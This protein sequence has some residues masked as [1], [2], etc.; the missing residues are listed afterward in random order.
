MSLR[1]ASTLTNPSESEWTFP[2]YIAQNRWM[3]GF[4]VLSCS[5]HSLLRLIA[6]KRTLYSSTLLMSAFLD[7]NYY[8]DKYINLRQEKYNTQTRIGNSYNITPIATNLN[9]TP[10]GYVTREKSLRRTEENYTRWALTCRRD[11]R[12]SISAVEPH[13]YRKTHFYLICLFLFWHRAVDYT[14]DTR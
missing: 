10:I 11:Q 13:T 12:I 8:N 7:N 2:E 5:L 6:H 14:L 1:L 4:S 9:I 3:R